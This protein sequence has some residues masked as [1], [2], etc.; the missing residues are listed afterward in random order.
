MCRGCDSEK[1]CAGH[2]ARWRT[3]WRERAQMN[4]PGRW[5]EGL[6]TALVSP[7]ETPLDFWFRTQRGC[8]CEGQGPGGC[9]RWPWLWQPVH[10]VDVASPGHGGSF[11]LTSNMS[12][13][14][15]KQAIDFC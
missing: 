8:I 5:R 6:R 4:V 3:W 15:G 7:D 12:F 2:S 1:M 9:P 11:G 10:P 14:R 13:P